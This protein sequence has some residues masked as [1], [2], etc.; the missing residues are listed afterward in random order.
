[1]PADCSALTYTASSSFANAIHKAI[2]VRATFCPSLQ[3]ML[4]AWHRH[5]R[6]TRSYGDRRSSTRE[7][8]NAEAPMYLKTKMSCR[9][10]SLFACT[11][12]CS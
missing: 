8:K 11:T 9:S 3:R 2:W 12:V 5:K 10:V 7:A 1:M 6:S 4:T